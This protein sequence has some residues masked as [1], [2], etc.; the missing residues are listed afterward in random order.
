MH[1]GTQRVYSVNYLACV[2]GA[3]KW[4]A[5]EGAREGDTR[6]ERERSLHRIMAKIGK[7]FPEK[8]EFAI[9]ARFA[10]E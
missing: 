4:W 2:A 3:W 6:G 9:V 10:S 5:K 1:R 8:I 7:T